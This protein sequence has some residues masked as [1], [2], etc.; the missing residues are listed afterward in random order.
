MGKKDFDAIIVGSGP[1]GLAAAIT[2]QREGL[3]VLLLESHNEI[4]GGC[5]SAQLTLPGFTH[6]VCSA[7]HPLAA[8]S[9]FFNSLPLHKHGLKF[10]YPETAAAHPLDNGTAALLKNDLNDTAQQLGA[11]EP[12]YKKLI[13]DVVKLWP[14]IED[15]ALGPLHFPAK[16]LKMAKFGM[17]ALLSAAQLSKR[18]HTNEGRAL[19]AGMAAHSIQPLT[20]ATTSAIALVLMAAAHLR[21]WP[22]PEKGASSIVNALGSYFISLGG[23]IQTGV[24]VTSLKQLPSA[25]AVLFDVSPK[26]LLSIAGEKFSAHYTSQL[27]KYRYGP[28]VFK[29]DWALAAPIPFTAEGARSAGTVHI[30]NSYEEIA[31]Y[32]KQ[33]W[34]GK[35]GNKPFVLLAQPS[36]FDRSRAPQDAHTAWA[37]CHVPNGSTQDMTEAIESQIERFAPGFRER[38]LA[39]HT[40]NSLQLED[41]NNNYVG[42]DIAAGVLDV[43]Q[44][45]TRPA[46]RWS[47]YRT[48]AKGLYICSASTPPG[49]GVHGMCGYHAAKRA[50]KDIFKR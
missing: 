47:P 32:E 48:S 9:P 29:M 18:F 34:E 3:S 7:V 30:G 20:N 39:R 26:Q 23:K 12:V 42:G 16:P 35:A 6:D 5:R 22:I 33:L 36:L 46:L 25:H 2:L 49:A 11:D 15:D 8:G 14:Q 41:Y 10:I 28:G 19:W 4:G 27:K 17:H 38:I 1:N 44:L 40:M 31:D 37:Y 45:F 21:G 43:R 24:H 50:L 13:G